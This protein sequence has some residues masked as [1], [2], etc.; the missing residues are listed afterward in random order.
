M[1]FVL[2]WSVTEVM[3]YSFYSFSLLNRVPH[4]LLWCRYFFCKFFLGDYRIFVRNQRVHF[5]YSLF[6]VLYPIGVTGEL[7]TVINSLTGIRERKIYT[8]ELPNQANI[9]FSYYYALCVFMLL[10]LPSKIFILKN[11][12]NLVKI[13]RN[14]FSF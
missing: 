10:Y 1:L 9:S 5:R 12:F 8:V 14:F 7:L 13:R 11:S 6:I 2:S 4:F 3:R